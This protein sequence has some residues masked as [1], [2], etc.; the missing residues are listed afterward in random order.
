MGGPNIQVHRGNVWVGVVP[1]TLS[2]SDAKALFDALEER[3]LAREGMSTL[4]YD[5]RALV[6]YE[7][8]V[9]DQARAMLK[10]T[11]AKLL[12]V[13]VVSVSARVKFTLSMIQWVTDRELRTFPSIEEALTW[14]RSLTP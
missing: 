1:S 9:M 6:D 14:A 2:S 8:G 3:I 4:V 12:G 11:D 7:R 10:A 13:A 5:A